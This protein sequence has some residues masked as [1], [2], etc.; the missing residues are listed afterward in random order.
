MVFYFVT[1]CERLDIIE[2][3]PF[4]QIA[5][6]FSF[7]QITLSEVT[8]EQL[9]ALIESIKNNPKLEGLHWQLIGYWITVNGDEA[10]PASNTTTTDN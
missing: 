6:I 3:F 4:W 1:T 9:D 8:H 5:F 2:L 7:M 10:T